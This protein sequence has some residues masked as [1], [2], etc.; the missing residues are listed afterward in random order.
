MLSMSEI[1][2]HC[3]LAAAFTAVVACAPV[4]QQQRPTV[5]N[6]EQRPAAN[7]LVLDFGG[8]DSVRLAGHG[9]GFL[10]DDPAYAGVEREE[11]ATLNFSGGSSKQLCRAVKL[12]DTEEV[13]LARD[14]VAARSGVLRIPQSAQF[15]VFD[16]EDRELLSRMAAEFIRQYCKSPACNPADAKAR[17]TAAVIERDLQKLFTDLAADPRLRLMQKRVEHAFIR[18]LSER[19]TAEDLR[20]LTRFY[21]QG[22]GKRFL[23]VQGRLFEEMVSTIMA[24]RGFGRYGKRPQPPATKPDPEHYKEVLGLFDELVRIQWAIA[25]PG[26]G[27]DRSGLQAIPLMVAGA[28][29]QRFDPLYDIWTEL[30]ARDRAAILAWRA[31]PLGTKER[32]AIFESARAIRKFFHPVEESI[33]VARA[34]STYEEKWRRL[35]Q[36]PSP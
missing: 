6:Q 19:L 25:D 2:R 4:S 12:E 33:R 34:I 10:C 27:K 23:A 36:T 21:S 24:Q 14:Y 3:T 26:E 7:D 22:I 13:R 17:R 11:T 18:G 1:Y 9:D 5:V 29:E 35:L 31:S 32:T 20:E 30:R 16:A 28:A 8:G 15:E